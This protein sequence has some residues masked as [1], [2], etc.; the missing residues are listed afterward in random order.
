MSKTDVAAVVLDRVERLLRRVAG[1]A[2]AS[3]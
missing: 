2:P 1:A 3:R